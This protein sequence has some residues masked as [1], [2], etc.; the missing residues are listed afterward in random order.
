MSKK[1]VEYFLNVPDSLM[2]VHIV[3]PANVFI[4]LTLRNLFFKL[5]IL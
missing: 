3:K 2:Q 5:F 4:E 1:Q